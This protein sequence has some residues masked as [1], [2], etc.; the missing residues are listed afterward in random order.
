MTTPAQNVDTTDDGQGGT[1]PGAD[2]PAVTPSTTDRDAGTDTTDARGGSRVDPPSP[3]HTVVE[4]SGP[5]AGYGAYKTGDADDHSRDPQPLGDTTTFGGIGGTALPPYRAPQEAPGATNF[6]TGSQAGV[7]AVNPGSPDAAVVGNNSGINPNAVEPGLTNS[8]NQVTHTDTTGYGAGGPTHV[9]AGS[10]VAAAPTAVTATVVP[11]RRA[12]DV[13]WTAP[14]NAVAAGVLGYV[15]ESN[16]TGTQMAGKD[17][18]SLEFE[19]GLEGGRTYTFTVFARTAN[20]NGYRSA[21]S[22][23]V[24]IP[25]GDLTADDTRAEGL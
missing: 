4:T 1:G 22:A 25:T 16:T 19:E 5:S 23:P 2:A 17:D 15:V 7:L 12:V 21:P 18:S 10:G 13:H 11:N 9:P 20:G 6:D 14:A 24:T 8:A 3:A